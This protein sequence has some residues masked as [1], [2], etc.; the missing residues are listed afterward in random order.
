MRV[1]QGSLIGPRAFLVTVNDYPDI[2]PTEI[3]F[4]F[5]VP[6]LHEFLLARENFHYIFIKI[7]LL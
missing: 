3:N 7:P 5:T 2:W 1:P 4:M 6:R